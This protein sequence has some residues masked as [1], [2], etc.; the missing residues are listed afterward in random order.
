MDGSGLPPPV[1]DHVA[2]ETPDLDTFRRVMADAFG[3]EVRDTDTGHTEVAVGPHRV[4]ATQAPEASGDPTRPSALARVGLGASDPATVTDALRG[5][6]LTVEE[7]AD[8]AEALDLSAA[9]WSGVPLRITTARH[10]DAPCPP[11]TNVQCIDH[12]GVASADNAL[13]RDRFCGTLGLAMESSQID[14][15][16]LIRVEQFT[17]DR[18]GVRVVHSQRGD[19]SGLRV[20]FVTVGDTEFEFLEDLYAASV[21]VRPSS[22]TA[23]DRGAIATYVERHGPGLHHLAL[24]VRDIDAALQASAAAGVDVLDRVGRPGGRGGRI[25]FLHPRS[26]GGVLFHF[27]ER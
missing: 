9:E 27:V 25:G 12:I 6:G 3:L 11:D 19:V 2:V 24:R 1:L 7:V 21:Q 23:G 10:T 22:S 16:S 14:T 15:E 26:T 18:Y 4:M 8:E 20:L 17:S 13:V 5:H